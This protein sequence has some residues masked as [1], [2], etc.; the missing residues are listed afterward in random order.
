MSITS[1]VVAAGMLT[2]IAGMVTFPF[3]T[4]PGIVLFLVGLLACILG[5]IFSPA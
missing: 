2:I 1:Q 5:R 4:V 3:A